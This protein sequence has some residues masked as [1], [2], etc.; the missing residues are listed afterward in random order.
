ML[1]IITNVTDAETM[2]NSN[3]CNGRRWPR[4]SWCQADLECS[5][6]LHY[7][8]WNRILISVKTLQGCHIP[9]V[10]HNVPDIRKLT[11]NFVSKFMD[12]KDINNVRRRKMKL[13]H[14]FCEYDEFEKLHLLEDRSSLF[15]W[16]FVYFLQSLYVTQTYSMFCK[17]L[18]HVPG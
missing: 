9:D 10:T 17:F 1:N 8:S 16:T 11:L 4:D 6:L 18:T 7:R 2:V 5:E 14:I 13:T 12:S 3:Y 15:S